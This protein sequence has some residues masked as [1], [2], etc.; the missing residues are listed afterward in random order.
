MAWWMADVS[1]SR[2]R[3]CFI[4]KERNPISN[5]YYLKR[6]NAFRRQSSTSSVSS[7]SFVVQHTAQNRKPGKC[8]FPVSIQKSRRMDSSALTRLSPER[9]GTRGS[10]RMRHERSRALK[11]LLAVSGGDLLAYSGSSMTLGSAAPNADSS[12]PPLPHM[13]RHG[14]GRQVVVM[15]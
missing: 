1:L 9:K 6:R 8:N 14:A 15:W 4:Y 3:R 13:R 12:P 5:L 10:H 2:V 7:N 11:R